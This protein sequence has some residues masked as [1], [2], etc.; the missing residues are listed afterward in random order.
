MRGRGVELMVM[1]DR[2]TSVFRRTYPG[3]VALAWRVLGESA[4][5]EDVAQETLASLADAA[6]LDRPDHEVDAWLRRVC[7]RRSFNVVRSRQRRADRVDRAARLESPVRTDAAAPVT[8][9]IRTEESD[10]VRA[11]LAALP[12]R[13]RA[14]LVLRHSGYRYAEIAATLDIA[15]GSVGVLLAR[16][17]RAFLQ[18]YPNDEG[19]DG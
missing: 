3:L 2:Y 13:Q 9:V 8:E 18:N 14:C 4:E 11:A 7:L 10:A 17:E 12:E 6:V 5:A 1:E 19:D 15:V 16:A